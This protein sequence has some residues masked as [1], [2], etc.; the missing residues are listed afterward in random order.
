M[1][2]EVDKL[3]KSLGGEPIQGTLLPEQQSQEPEPAP[4]PGQQEQSARRG[5]KERSETTGGGASRPALTKN[6]R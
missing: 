6:G 5:G 3:T 2:E 1:T 4:E